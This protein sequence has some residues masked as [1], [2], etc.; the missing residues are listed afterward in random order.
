MAFKRTN[1]SF[2]PPLLPNQT[3]YSWGAVFHEQSGN[4]SVERSRS[5]LFG[6]IRRGLHFHIPSQLDTF[7]ANKQLALGTPERL[8]QIA[9][10][11]PYYTRFRIPS[12]SSR[13]L[14]LARGNS[15]YGV[16]QAL[17]MAKTAIYPPPPRRSC[18]QCV[19]DDLAELGFACWRRDHRLP[20][21]LVCPKHGT[22]LLSLPYDHRNIHNENFLCP[23][24][25]WN[26]VGGSVYPNWPATTLVTLNRLA[27]LGTD[28][29][30]GN[31][32]GSE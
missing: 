8:I 32:M 1:L 22:T 31:N 7:C 27:K 23:D 10:T 9:T 2:I 24:E 21:V 11:V 15:S 3:L 4:S 16:A 30:S 25:N 6:L 17:G 26:L 20:G 29:A 28:M 14:K 18:Y 19:Q 13:I 12:V 5:Q